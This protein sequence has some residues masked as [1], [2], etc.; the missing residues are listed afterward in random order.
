MIQTYL[1][2]PE[3]ARARD[4][5]DLPVRSFLTADHREGARAFMEKRKPVFRGG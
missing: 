2:D 1:R 4:L 3:F 5:Y